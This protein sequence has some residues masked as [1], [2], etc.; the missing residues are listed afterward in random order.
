[1]RLGLC[2]EAEVETSSWVGA[3]SSKHAQLVGVNSYLSLLIGEARSKT[4]KVAVTWS[5]VHW[6]VNHL[7][8][9]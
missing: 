6:V 3:H 1:M 7:T 4:S 9:C 8:L 5:G 2:I